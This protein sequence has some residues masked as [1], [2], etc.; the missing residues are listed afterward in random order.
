[1]VSSYYSTIASYNKLHVNLYIYIHF[2]PPY[3]IDVRFSSHTFKT[4]ATTSRL[5]FRC[6]I[7]LSVFVVVVVCMYIFTSECTFWHISASGHYTCCSEYTEMY[8]IT[9]RRIECL[10]RTYNMCECSAVSSKSHRYRREEIFRRVLCP[11]SNSY[12]VRRV[13]VDYPPLL[14]ARILMQLFKVK[15]R[16]DNLNSVAVDTGKL[17]AS[18]GWLADLIFF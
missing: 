8:M 11:D 16:G 15:R 10:I 5:H 18:S 9:V 1:M 2:K 17:Y 13:P 4:S 6:Y 12:L 3:M 14:L 7:H